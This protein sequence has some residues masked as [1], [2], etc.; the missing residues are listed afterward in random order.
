[1]RKIDAHT[2]PH[3]TADPGTFTLPALMQPLL[4]RADGLPVR[5]YRVAFGHGGRTH[6]HRHDGIQVLVGLEG[7]CVVEDRRDRRIE[8]RPGDVVVVDAGEE[9]WHGAAP[10]DTAVHLAINLGQDTSWTGPVDADG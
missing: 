7:C 1:M 4:G 5:L 9:H 10:G 2:R 3:G 8:L 6:W